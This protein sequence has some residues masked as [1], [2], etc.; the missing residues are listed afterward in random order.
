MCRTDRQTNTQA[1]QTNRQTDRQDRHLQAGQAG[2]QTGQ[3]DRRVHKGG[4][5][6]PLQMNPPRSF[7]FRF[8]ING[9]C[10]M[11]AHCEH[12]F[13]AIDPAARPCFIACACDIHS[14]F[15]HLIVAKRARPCS[16]GPGQ[17][18]TALS[19]RGKCGSFRCKTV[20]TASVRKGAMT[21]RRASTATLFSLQNEERRMQSHRFFWSL[22]IRGRNSNQWKKPSNR[23]L[24]FVTENR[25]FPTFCLAAS[26]EG[27][28]L[29]SLWRSRK[30]KR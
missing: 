17:L 1:G 10:R 24:F 9:I 19:R 20:S 15:K 22:G 4:G 3:T 28:E 26:S 11:R 12:V 27:K 29:F 18:L 6:S 21:R 2:H 8:K 16:S 13:A 7:K 14:T 25:F 30:A 23:V 5:G